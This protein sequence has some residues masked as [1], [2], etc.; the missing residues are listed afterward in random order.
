MEAMV[1]QGRNIKKLREM[2]GIKQETLASELGWNQKRI[3]VLEQKEQIDLPVLEQISAILN[4]PVEVITNFDEDKA[5]HNINNNFHD[6]AVQNQ[7]NP[8][9]KIIELYEEKTALYERMLQE[10][11]GLIQRLEALLNR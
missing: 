9:E 3:S 2:L 11:E 4:I 7:F 8:M 10:K 1:H 5:I 6:H